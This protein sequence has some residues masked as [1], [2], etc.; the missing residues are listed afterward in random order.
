MART[1][2]AMRTWT[3]EEASALTHRPFQHSHPLAVF[4]CLTDMVLLYVDS[5]HMLRSPS[6]LSQCAVRLE[7]YSL[8]IVLERIRM[9]QHVD[10]VSSE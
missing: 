7:G 3:E 9:L 5:L 2:A 1:Y 4:S 10:Q 8:A 6:L